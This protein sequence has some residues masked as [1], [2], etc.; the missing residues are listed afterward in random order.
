MWARSFFMSNKEEIVPERFD[1][2]RLKKESVA[3]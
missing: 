2:I 1:Q 3:A